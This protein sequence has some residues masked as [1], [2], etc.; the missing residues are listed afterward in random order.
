VRT[1]L[2][3]DLIRD[4]ELNLSAPVP[5]FYEREGS[6]EIGDK[7]RDAIK[8]GEEKQRRRVK[9]KRVTEVSRRNRRNKQFPD[10]ALRS[11]LRKD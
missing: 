4:D 2:D 7:V 6:K 5:P 9:R 11:A 8:R 10:F 1:L 3:T